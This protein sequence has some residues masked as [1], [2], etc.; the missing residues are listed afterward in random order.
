MRTILTIRD[1]DFI[2]NAPYLDNSDFKKREAV[3]AVLSDNDGRI[4][5][6]YSKNRNYYKLPGGGIDPGEDNITALHREIIE[7]TGCRAEIVREVGQIIE[8]R[9]QIELIQTSY[10]YTAKLIEDTGETH[11]TDYE[12]PEQFE[13]TWAD[14]L[15]HAIS[16]FEQVASK[17]Y[18]I[19][20]MTKRDLE[21]VKSTSRQKL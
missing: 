7:E 14:N 15:T 5:L 19:Q 12:T 4:A 20:Y 1:Q 18:G 11:F 6:I 9:D 17:D 10:C 8:F 21:F 13:V 3:R 2:K 16:L